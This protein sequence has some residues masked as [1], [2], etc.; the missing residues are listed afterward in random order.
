MRFFIDECISPTLSRH[1]NQ[2]LHDAIHPRGRGRLRD[3]DHVVFAHAIAEDRVIVTENAEH[4][5]KLAGGV[6]LHAGVI[7]LPSVAHAEAQLACPSRAF[8][9]CPATLASTPVSSPACPRRHQDDWQFA[10]QSLHDVRP[11]C[12]WP[13]V[14][15]RARCGSARVQREHERGDARL[16]DRKARRIDRGVEIAVADGIG[17]A[18]PELGH[19][20]VLRDAA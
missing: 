17:G 4:F 7:I 3:P 13:G 10:E 18:E 2:R 20:S 1:L 6:D 9:S 5:R 15:S 16:G 14:A 19:I 11:R 12:I 8:R